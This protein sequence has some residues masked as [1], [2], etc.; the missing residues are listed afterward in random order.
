M[1]LSGRLRTVLLTLTT[2]A[3]P[4]T[5]L[6]HLLHKH[7]DRAQTFPVSAGTAHVF[8]LEAEPD[9]CTAALLLDVDAIALVR[10]RPGAAPSAFTLGQYVNDRPYAAGSMLAV[11]IGSVFS[12]AMKGRCIARPE[13]AATP[14]P[15]SVRIPTL[16]CRGGAELVERLFVPL[17]WQVESTAIPLDPQFPDWGDSRYRDVTLTGELRLSAA[18]QHLYVLIPVL[19]GGKH[20]WVGEDEVEKLLRVGADWLATHP[21]RALISERYLAHRRSYVRSAL[22]QLA[23]A[24]DTDVDALD[25]ALAEPAVTQVPQRQEP[26]HAQRRAAVL[27]VLRAGGAKR[28]LD[29]GCGD[30][31][32]LRELIAEPSFTEIVGID[33]SVRAL[34]A[35]ER[36]LHLDRIP[37]R[38]RERERITLRQSALTYADAT[39][40]GYDA[41]VLMEVIEHVDES[42]L[43]ALENAVFGVARPGTVVVT[44]PNVEYNVRFETL[45]HGAFRHG[46]HR[47]EW[48]REQFRTWAAGVAARYGYTVR[49]LPVG[50]EDPEVGAPTQVG[51]FAR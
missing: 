24:D 27:E 4:A 46:D 12:S 49:Y 9:R 5:D 3:E 44:T 16:P 19:D 18:L 45:P 39:L 13:L 7:P 35:A 41:A 25:N 23:E 33:V 37:E 6:G 28:V 8:Y 10:G 26:L 51:V 20:Y 50:P 42:R 47:F 30:G 43:P 34:A 48:T 22:E 29:L 40:V 21:E 36:K 31:A 32:L 38:Q 17:G 2:T 11:A 15:L 14:I 1:R